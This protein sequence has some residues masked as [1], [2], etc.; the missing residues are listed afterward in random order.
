MFKHA[1]EER[2][3]VLCYKSPTNCDAQLSESNF[4]I[5]SKPKVVESLSF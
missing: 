3:V 2:N 4:Q 5:R 1:L